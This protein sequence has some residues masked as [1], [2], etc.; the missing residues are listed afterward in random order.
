MNIAGRDIPVA[1]PKFLI[2]LKLKAGGPRDLLDVQELLAS[3]LVDRALLTEL[4]A[5]YQVE[6][7]HL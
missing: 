7:C 2:I 4:E 5:C 6:I 1:S 3:G